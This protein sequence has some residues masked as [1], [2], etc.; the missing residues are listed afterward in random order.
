[1]EYDRRY[2]HEKYTLGFA[3]RGGT[4][5]FY[6]SIE[7]NTMAHGPG[8]DRGGKD[9]EAD[10][11]FGRILQ[12]SDG[13]EI[14][15]HMKK[16]PGGAKPNGFISDQQNFIAIDSLRLLSQREVRDVL[17]MFSSSKPITSR[18][19]HEYE[20]NWT[21][22]QEDSDNLRRT[23]AGGDDTESYHLRRIQKSLP[24]YCS[25]YLQSIG[26]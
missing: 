13:I 14:V 4:N 7:N 20:Q 21:K 23:P 8:T 10:T 17:E 18:N 11:V 15:Q 1:M 9:P 25:R 2:P 24:G 3:G 6:I 16:Q 19:C 22:I 26:R 5:A 12:Q